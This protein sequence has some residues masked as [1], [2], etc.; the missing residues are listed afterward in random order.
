M[1]VSTDVSFDSTTPQCQRAAGASAEHSAALRQGPYTVC[2][3]TL[4]R[5]TPGFVSAWLP[6][7][8][9]P[10]P[11]ELLVRPE[12]VG[13]HLGVYHLQ[14]ALF[15]GWRLLSFGFRVLLS[16]NTALGFKLLKTSI[17]VFSDAY[18]TSFFFFFFFFQMYIALI[19]LHAL[20]MVGFHFL[21]C[22]EED[23]TSE[24]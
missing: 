2:E 6:T 17:L 8:L 14:I 15:G 13:G 23:W 1:L 3:A 11:L 9:L 12:W 16:L 21:Y 4:R 20:I 7:E 5:G 24:Y 19:S 18:V 22:F 10:M